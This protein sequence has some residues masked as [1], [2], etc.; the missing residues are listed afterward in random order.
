MSYWIVE[1]WIVTGCPRKP[2]RNNDL[3]EI[4]GWIFILAIVLPD[5]F[6][7]GGCR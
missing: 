6:L 1:E 2:P 3:D 7:L 5:A 4:I